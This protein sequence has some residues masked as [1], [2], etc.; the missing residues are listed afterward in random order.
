MDYLNTLE[1]AITYIEEHLGDV[2]AEEVACHTGYSYYHLTRLFSAVIGESLGSYI[3]KRR[4]AESAQKL[5]YTDMRIIDIAMQY[6]FESS[7]AFSRA[8]KSVYKTSPVIYRKNRIETIISAK[9]PLSYQ[10][11]SHVAFGVTVKPA[12]INTSDILV[13]GIRGK[14][15]LNHNTIPLLWQQF[16]NVHASIPNT[17]L[18]GRTFGICEYDESESGDTPYTMNGDVIFSEVVGTEVTSFEAMP[19]WAIAKTIKAGKY[20]VFTHKGSLKNLIKTYN[21]IWGTWFLGSKVELDCR[22]DFEVY[23]QR[24]LGYDHPESQMDIYIPVV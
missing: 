16:I 10:L 6:G 18:S 19:D 5:L 15:S 21:Y 17:S 3:K 23:D 8:F 20:A 12:I 24:F 2:G 14:T 9:K 1:K 11:L 4:L 13:A 22:E 7:E